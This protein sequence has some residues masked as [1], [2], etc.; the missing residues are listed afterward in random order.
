MEQKIIGAIVKMLVMAIELN[1][2]GMVIQCS[3]NDN[4]EFL[5]GSV[6]GYCV[7]TDCENNTIGVSVTVAYNGELYKAEMYTNGE[8]KLIQGDAEGF[9]EACD[10]YTQAW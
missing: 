7:A 3:N 8:V 9:I 2:T 10:E 4:I 1:Q 6:D 5:D